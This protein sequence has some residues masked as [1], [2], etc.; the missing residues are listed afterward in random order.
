MEQGQERRRH[1]WTR[2]QQREK[3]QPHPPHPSQHCAARAVSAS[4]CPPAPGSLTAA[5]PEDLLPARRRS[6][7]RCA[8]AEEGGLSERRRARWMRQEATA[9]SWC[10]ASDRR[11]EVEKNGASSRTQVRHLFLMLLRLLRVRQCRLRSCSALLLQ[12]RR[13]TTRTTTRW[14]S[15][16]TVR[17]DGEDASLQTR[18]S[19]SSGAWGQLQLSAD[20]ASAVVSRELPLVVAGRE[21]GRR[22]L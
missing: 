5:A 15:H 20:C 14:K 21:G 17:L 16:N 6:P 13:T 1:R 4:A 11:R 7:W 10:A 8:Q 18:R 12:L 3:Q 2:P 22:R 19:T 9:T